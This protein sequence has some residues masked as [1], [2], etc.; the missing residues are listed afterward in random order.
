MFENK[1][2]KWYGSYSRAGK[3]SAENF[4]SIIHKDDILK[5]EKKRV[6]SLYEIQKNN[7][8]YLD[9][10][11]NFNKIINTKYTIK[12]NS[13][14]HKKRKVNIY[15]KKD[16]FKFKYHNLHY[17]NLKHKNEIYIEPSCTKYNPK[18]DFIHKKINTGPKWEDLL[19]RNVPI[20][21]M[22]NSNFFLISEYTNKK[23]NKSSSK[24][25]T[26]RE[27]KGFDNIFINKKNENFN[28]Q[29]NLKLKINKPF[30]KN[31]NSKDIKNKDK[32]KYKNKTI[33]FHKKKRNLK[34]S[35]NE[36]NCPK[37]NN[38]ENSDLDSPLLRRLSAITPEVYEIPDITK[39]MSQQ[40]KENI[41]QFKKLLM[42]KTSLNY[43]LTRERSLS[44]VTYKKPYYNYKKRKQFIGIDPNLNFDINKI[45]NKY[46]NHVFYD[47]PNFD[48]MTS[49]PYDK[50]NPLPN[51]MQKM[52][53]RMSV[54]NYNDKT[55]EL[56]EYS[57]GKFLSAYNSFFPKSSFN[58]IINL[59]LLK[60]SNIN[61]NMEE[62]NEKQ[63]E[64]IINKIKNKNYEKLIL[65]GALN[66]FDKITF[67]ADTKKKKFN[68]PLLIKLLLNENLI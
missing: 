58:S 65:D 63:I 24:N 21:N 20:R 18:Y 33:Y 14:N 34:L 55:L 15:N 44:L 42:P 50:N 6:K 30:N 61:K 40:D 1:T 41:K 4:Y 51:F 28:K 66:K 23:V 13:T 62:Y 56:N 7:L 27:S 17:E 8:D 43:S 39:S 37:I 3:I 49:R 9:G 25:I 68:K 38:D 31:Y 2:K 36:A 57:D 48:Y 11:I 10:K 67:K 32:S 53:D 47:G 29:N 60:G 52:H 26:N 64:K 16:P 46:N 22:E 54:Y 19:G 45:I 12:I 5:R 35:L 59:S